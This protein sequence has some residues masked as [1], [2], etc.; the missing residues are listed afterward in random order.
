MASASRSS[1]HTA[2]VCQWR[3]GWPRATAAAAGH[4]LVVLET[5]LR[6]PEAIELYCSAGYQEI[7][8]F[9]YYKDAPLSRCFGKRVS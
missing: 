8:G 3:T 5:G 6:Q 4:D 2:A 7:D 1:E 9:G